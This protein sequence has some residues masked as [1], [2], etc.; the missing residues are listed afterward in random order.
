MSYISVF[1][2]SKNAREDSSFCL[3]IGDSRAGLRRD[4][5]AAWQ[6]TV[7]DARDMFQF[8]KT[9]EVLVPSSNLACMLGNA[10]LWGHG[11]MSRQMQLGGRGQQSLCWADD[12]MSGLPCQGRDRAQWHHGI[13]QLTVSGSVV[14]S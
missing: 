2:A 7:Q 8:G 3:A 13:A 1:E 10:M 11:S 4:T 12:V 5:S 9:G 6:D 14:Y